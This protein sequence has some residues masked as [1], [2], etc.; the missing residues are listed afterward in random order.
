MRAHLLNKHVGGVGETHNIGYMSNSDNTRMSE[1]GEELVKREVIENGKQIFFGVEM[2]IGRPE[3]TE[4]PHLVDPDLAGMLVNEVSMRV[5]EVTPF[6]NEEG[7][8]DLELRNVFL[9]DELGVTDEDVSQSNSGKLTFPTQMPDSE[10][11]SKIQGRHTKRLKSESNKARTTTLDMFT[12]PSKAQEIVLK[13]QAQLRKAP[14]SKE[15]TRILEEVDKALMG[16]KVPDEARLFQLRKLAEVGRQSSTVNSTKKKESEKA[17]KNAKSS[18][19]KSFIAK[20]NLNEK[21]VEFVLN[22]SDEMFARVET[23]MANGAKLREALN[24]QN[25]REPRYSTILEGL[26]RGGITKFF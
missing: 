9:V 23:L 7:E 21:D 16:E 13:A 17:K 5:A 3:L 20:H 25:L 1:L 8:D 11:L 15:R 22:L 2:P 10:T 4:L 24:A 12:L 18:D 26:Q 19:R 6:V 14:S